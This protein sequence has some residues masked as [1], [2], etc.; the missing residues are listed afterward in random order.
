LQRYEPLSSNNDSGLSDSDPDL[1][2][3]DNGCSSEA[4]KQ[5]GSSVRINIP[6]DPVD[7]QRLV[8]WKKEGKP[9]D[10]IFKKFPGRTYPAIRTR[11]SMVRP[12]SE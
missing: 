1:S 2:S 11:W 7:E 10:W 3:N 4:E 8:A 12:R 9:W 6:W 5:G